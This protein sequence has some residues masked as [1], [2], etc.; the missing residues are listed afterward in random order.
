MAVVGVQN[1]LPFRTCQ[2]KSNRRLIFCHIDGQALV[3]WLCV[4]HLCGEAGTKIRR[5][6]SACRPEGHEPRKTRNT[7]KEV[8][9]PSFADFAWFAVPSLV[10][11]GRRLRLA[12]YRRRRTS[13][14]SSGPGGPD[15]RW[16]SVLTE[17]LTVQPRFEGCNRLGV[18]LPDP[19]FGQAQH[20]GNLAQ[21]HILVIIESQHLL[22]GGG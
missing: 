10:V 12:G 11:I 18:N 19:R 21:A 4:L 2:E 20:G 5:E 9:R 1:T 16:S 3:I 6:R 15:F 22:L 13:P 14:L 17:V 8:A 7:R